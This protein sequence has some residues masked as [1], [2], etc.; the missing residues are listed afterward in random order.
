VNQIR[1]SLPAELASPIQ[2]VLGRLH[3]VQRS[4]AGWT[5]RC[6]S[7]E[8]ALNSLSIGIGDDGR[9]L[10]KCFAGCLV[11]PIVR[12]L[13]LK[14][15]DLF[16]DGDR[17]ERDH[18]EAP[19]VTGVTALQPPGLSVK[20]LAQ[21]KQLPEGF[22]RELGIS[23]VRRNGAPTIRI[24]YHGPAGELRS[25][26]FRRS[27]DGPQRFAW[28]TGDKVALYGLDRL[29]AI[30]KKGWVLLVEG[31]SDSWT[32]WHY[33]LPALGLPGKA[34]WRSC[35]REH[36]E[37]LQV[38]LWQEPSAEDLTLRVSADMPDLRVIPA[39]AEIKDL[40]EAHLQG[41]DVIKLLDELKA[42][43]V[44][45]KQLRR[46]REDHRVADLRTAA[47]PVLGAE[48]PLDLVR[49]AI[50]AQGYGGDLGPAVIT[51]LAATSRLLKMR[52]GSMPVHLLLVGPPS[53]GKSYTM[54]VVLRLMPPEG[55]QEIEAGSPRVLIYDDADLRH[56]V[57]I[58][59][60]ADSLPAGEDNPAASA[61][62]NLLQEHELKYKVTVRAPE[63][64]D[65][66]VRE[67]L[68]PGPTV[69]FTTAVRRLGPQLD[70]RLFTLEVPDGLGQ[71]RQA[72]ATQATIETQGVKDPDPTLVAFQ[73]YLQACAPFDVVVPF[74]FNLSNAIGQAA[75]APRITRDYT[76]LLSLIKAVTVLRH[77]KRGTVNG[78]LVAEI[79][80]YAAVY[81]LVR[82]MYEGTV[83]G[84]SGA[85]REVVLAV[86]GLQHAGDGTVSVT[87]VALHLGI[88]KMAASRRVKAALTN[89]WLVND[90]S[91]RGYPFK[92]KVGEPLPER[93][94]LPAPGTLTACNGVTP[95]TDGQRPPS[96]P[97]V[98]TV[99]EEVELF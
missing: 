12:A 81:D 95:L 66:Q 32:A 86:E 11:Q 21:A 58:F 1:D 7:H 49:R 50:R 14:V 39:P 2:K 73:A 52:A 28:R 53:A 82:D 98:A 16:V 99:L 76:R 62:R 72:L 54:K 20:A 5:A 51:Y 88:T 37:G 69:L 97:L 80:D 91:R 24:P 90:E 56:R 33:D 40:S 31:E 85:L 71:V 19:P 38:F 4:Q 93:T 83:T 30:R 61:I 65:Y 22:L 77:H 48:D 45:V 60:E 89:G 42:H 9:V 44:P 68:R 23:E 3:N 18:P 92:L 29:K 13:G 57:V 34:T 36:L 74:A 46:Q 64:G 55:Y 17:H 78:R 63:T 70:T 94:G 59:G 8:D 75:A 27:L 79:E 96:S 6:P 26:R 15:K 41:R 87:D 25:V 35:W 47:G 43:S 10:L 84:V 67:V